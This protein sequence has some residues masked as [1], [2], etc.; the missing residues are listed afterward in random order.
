[1]RVLLFA[2]AGTSV[3]LGVPAMRPMVLQFRTHLVERALAPDLLNRMDK[4]I[5]DSD[6]DMENLI[7]Q[8]DSLADG[9]QTLED[10]GDNVK[11]E[12]PKH[13]SVAR[14]EAEWFVQH[15]CERITPSDA[16]KMWEPTLRHIGGHQLT[17]ATTNYDR[18]IEM[19]A[20]K[21]RLPFCDGF[22]EFGETEW[23]EWAGFAGSP[24]LRILKIHGSTDW[25]HSTDGESVIKLRHAIPVFGE[26]SIVVD[27]E[28]RIVVRNAAVL[29]SREKKKNQ[30][31]YPQVGY[32]L[33]RAAYEAD[34]AIFV[35]TSFRDPDILDI[36]RTCT[37]RIATFA[38]SKSGQYP[39]INL[40]SSTRI[41]KQSA[42]CFFISILPTALTAPSKEEFAYSLER[43]TGTTTSIL[44]WLVVA[45]DSSRT[46]SDR[47]AA[48]DKLAEEGVSI[49]ESEISSL[50]SDPSTA[51]RKYALGLVLA[52]H[53]KDSLI[54]KV[55]ELAEQEQGSEFGIEAETLMKLIEIL[56]Q[57]A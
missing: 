19:A 48:I 3:E 5:Q 26:L 27:G 49:G 23:A 30:L 43:S 13:V 44:E 52:S 24:T 50:L 10:W 32:E 47:L 7:E 1:M 22:G 14:T 9:Y 33:R 29:P 4:V 53:E 21:L 8:L 42:S 25:Y 36:C 38:V 55:A 11:G 6:Y 41:L 15:V 34:I 31:P 35:G 46:V 16:N 57:S 39:G 56:E 18:A 2:G 37:A 45:T 51:V 54:Q 12:L 17:I 28:K 40:P 20:T